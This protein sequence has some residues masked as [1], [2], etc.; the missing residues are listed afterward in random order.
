MF[1]NFLKTLQSLNAQPTNVC[2]CHT[3]HVVW[4]VQHEAYFMCCHRLNLKFL[5]SDSDSPYNSNQDD[6]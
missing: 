1:L 6:I 2:D 5:S 4:A 3:M